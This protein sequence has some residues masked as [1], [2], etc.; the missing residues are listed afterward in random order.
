MWRFQVDF[1]IMKL[2]VCDECGLQ[3]TPKALQSH[4]THNHSRESFPCAECGK[5]FTAVTRLQAHRNQAHSTDN[6][7]KQCDKKF[8][9]KSSLNNH[10]RTFHGE[11]K[12]ECNVCHDFFSMLKILS[13]HK[14]NHLGSSVNKLLKL[15]I[16]NLTKYGSFTS[17]RWLKQKLM[18]WPLK[19]VSTTSIP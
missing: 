3:L 16:R 13:Q 11:E 19:N 1:V 14:R 8:S 7:C 2:L 9:Y 15:P 4:Q 6:S 5:V 18:D 10:V 12:R 17:S